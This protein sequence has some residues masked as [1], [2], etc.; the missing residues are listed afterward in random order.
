MDVKI[1]ESTERKQ[2][3]E[4]LAAVDFELVGIGWT[5]LLAAIEVGG[6]GRRTFTV[7]DEVDGADEW[8]VVSI[9]PTV[10]P[11]HVSDRNFVRRQV[12]LIEPSQFRIVND[13][14]QKE[15]K[16]K[17]KMETMTFVATAATGTSTA[18]ST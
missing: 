10:F 11:A 7:E 5:V 1:A 14:L 8:E 2:G 3:R 13:I 15:C 4:V 16:G 18:T 6:V 17:G 12:M 9:V